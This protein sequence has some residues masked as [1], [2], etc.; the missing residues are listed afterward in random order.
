[1]FMLK[2]YG[3]YSNVRKCLHYLE[4]MNDNIAI[5]KM[6]IYIISIFNDFVFYNASG[7][8]F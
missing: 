7:K 3:K 6:D 1:M 4:N 2:F 8:A 5:K